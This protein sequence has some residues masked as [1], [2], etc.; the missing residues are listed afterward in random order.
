MFPRPP[1]RQ[2]LVASKQT[3][4]QNNEK[5]IRFYNFAQ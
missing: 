1:S 5:I 3:A 2:L 4:Q